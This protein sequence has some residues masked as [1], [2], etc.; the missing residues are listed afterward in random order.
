MASKV[1]AIGRPVVSLAQGS[2]IELGSGT[3][4]ISRVPNTPLGVARPVV[5]RTMRPG[6][7]IA[8]GDHTGLS[9]T[10]ICA[11]TS[12]VI[13]RRVLIGADVLIADTDFHPVDTLPRRFEPESRAAAAPIVIGDDVFLGARSMILKGVEIGAGTVVG[14]GAVVTASLPPGV[15]AGGI[16]CRVLRPLENASRDDDTVFLP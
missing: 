12:V 7:R 3:T 5:L 13:G 16:P 2:T 6:A 10:T 14:A 15:V 8:I 9:G 1:T 11:S 4:L